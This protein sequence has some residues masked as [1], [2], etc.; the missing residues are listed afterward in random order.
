MGAKSC[1]NG[2]MMN[3][4]SV[5]LMG[6]AVGCFAEQVAQAARPF[7][8]TKYGE[9]AKLFT[10]RGKGGLEM[11]VTDCGGKVVRLFAP[12]KAG[13]LV[14]VTVGFDDV[15]GWEKTDAYFGAIIGRYANR[16]A[17]AAFELDGK[18]YKLAAND[19]GH[20]ACLHGGTRGWDAY[21][22][23]AE[24]FTNG[25]DVGIVF[26]RTSPDGEENFPGTVAVKVVYT[27]TPDNTWRIEYAATTDKPTYIG[28]TQHTYFNLEGAGTMLNHEMQIAASNYLAI[29][30]NLAPIGAPRSVEG[31][32]FDF[33]EFHTIG[34]RI[35]AAEPSLQNG[36]GYDH[37]WCL[38]GAGFR[39]ALTLKT[40]ARALEVWTDQPGI[41]VYAGNFISDDWTMKDG[42][43]MARRGHV[44]LETQH[45]P[46][47]PNR[48]D[49]PSAVLRPGE[50]YQS[51]TE[52]RFKA[53]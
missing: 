5:S 14:D 11:Q 8:V 48:P 19:A 31:T 53:L 52:Y 30:A 2:R 23:A 6:G 20:N 9:A 10:L 45:Y 46:N 49:F 13:A 29:D 51:K 15:T 40:A 7:G 50:T 42:L 43:P 12:D 26:T 34:E 33:R 24:P 21:V 3:V 41:Q 18:T 47:T 44:A 27:I 28:M 17:G 25:D 1:Y 35:D 32:P 4:K 38:D 39:K 22:W 36:A 37:N 16:I